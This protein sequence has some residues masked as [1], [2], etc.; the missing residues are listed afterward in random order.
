MW[1]RGGSYA[2]AG[3]LAAA[4]LTG[5]GSGGGAGTPAEGQTGGQAEG[6]NEAP[7]EQA[8][9]AYLDAPKQLTIFSASGE[10]EERFNQNYGDAIRKKFPN[11]TMTFIQSKAGST[12]VDM[13]ASGTPIDIIFGSI[14]TFHAGVFNH[15]MHRDLEPLM[16]QSRYDSSKLEPTL[17]ELQRKLGGGAIYGLPVWTATSGLFYNKSLFDKFG[18]SYPTDGMTWPELTELA[19]KM[20][21]SDGGVQYYGYATSPG[22]QMATNQY[23]LNPIDPKTLKSDFTSE[24]WKKFMQSIVDLYTLPGYDF[25]TNTQLGVAQQR[26]LFEQEQRVAMYTNFSGGTPPET[27]NW[28]AVSVP[29]YPDAP[30]IG[31]QVY[32]NYW[33][34]TMTSKQPNEAFELIACL[35]SEPFQIDMNRRGLATVL[36]DPAIHKQYGQGLPKF[37]GKNVAALFP[38]KQASPT[39]YTEFQNVAQSQFHVAFTEIVLGAKDINTALRDA[40]AAVDKHISENK[41]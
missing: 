11:L 4:M 37:Q 41:K 39:T 15:N 14:G 1:N 2:L 27:M 20:T 13:L 38:A 36:K 25:T 17:L 32:P 6:Q 33:Y 19:R 24:P 21:R 40:A 9:Q 31:S 30:G 12:M 23:G 22:S 10:T 5:C 16:K 34:V 7:V 29:Y 8:P 28:D 26:A 18:V 35:T 3:I